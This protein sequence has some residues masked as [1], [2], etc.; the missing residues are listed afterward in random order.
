MAEEFL[1]LMAEYCEE[2]QEK[3]DRWYNALQAAGFQGQQ[4]PGLKH[5]LSIATF[6]LEQE[7]AAKALVHRLA[8]RLA[9]RK[10]AIRHVGVM[11][12][13]R[14]LF[15][16]PD[17]TEELVQLQKATGC[18]QVG[19][20]LWLPHTTMLM[21]EPEVIGR[22]LPVLMQHFTPLLATIDRLELCA[23]WPARHILTLELKGKQE[24]S[25]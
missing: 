5:H 19:G 13:G 3:I 1:C 14:V 23:F 2:D 25:G 16:A 12:G 9:S 20:H 10:A 22:A 6:P 17:M 11:P 24:I 15:A 21:D 7:E 8:A 18:E 4:T